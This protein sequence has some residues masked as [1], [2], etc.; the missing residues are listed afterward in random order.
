MSVESSCRKSVLI[1][2][3]GVCC[4]TIAFT[5]EIACD[6]KLKEDPK[7]EHVFTQLVRGLRKLLL[8]EKCFRGDV[9]DTFFDSGD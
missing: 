3:R 9:K 5:F 7:C 2:V 4:D 6:A 8:I 1:I